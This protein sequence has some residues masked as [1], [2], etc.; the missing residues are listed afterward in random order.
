LSPRTHTRVVLIVVDIDMVFGK[1]L[2]LEDR[3]CGPHLSRNA[4]ASKHSER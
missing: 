1:D 3:S 4:E 2:R